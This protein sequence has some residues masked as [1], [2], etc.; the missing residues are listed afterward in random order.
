M[1]K[2]EMLGGTIGNKLE[3]EQKVTAIKNRGMTG[4][5][6]VHVCGVYLQGLRV[7]YMKLLNGCWTILR[8]AERMKNERGTETKRKRAREGKSVKQDSKKVKKGLAVETAVVT[9]AVS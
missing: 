6:G 2:P 1:E 5:M 7:G 9:C 4:M 3:S 8:N